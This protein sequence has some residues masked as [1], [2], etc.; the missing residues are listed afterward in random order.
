MIRKG[1]LRL[2]FLS[3]NDRKINNIWKNASFLQSF[4]NLCII[5]C[6]LLGDVVLFQWQ[7]DCIIV[8]NTVVINMTY[9]SYF[10]NIW[11]GEKPERKSFKLDLGVKNVRE[12]NE[13]E[14]KKN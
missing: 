14:L 5:S 11:T 13:G 12:D 1:G 6:R 2:P 10:F 4:T 7:K 3:Y 9:L 8:I